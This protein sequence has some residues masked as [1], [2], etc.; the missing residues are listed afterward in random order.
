MARY[1]DV[2]LD[3][4]YPNGTDGHLYEYELIYYPHNDDANGFKIPEPDTVLGQDVGDLGPDKERYRWFFLTKN[5]RA[6]DNFEPIIRYN[7]Q[8]GKSGA[9]FEDGLEEV[10]DVDGWLRGFAYSAVVGSSD[11]IASGFEHNGMYYA[12]PDGRVVSL[13]HDMDFSWNSGL[14]IFANPE[15][16]KLTQDGRRRRIYLGHLHDIISTTFN[17]NYMTMWSIHL[18]SLDPA[19]YWSSTRSYINSRANNVLSQIN[20][21]ISPVGFII[22]TAS[23]LIVNGSAA[24]I[25]GEGWVN[26]RNIRLRGSS[27]PLIVN[28][29]DS[30]SWELTVPAPPGQSTLI[31]EALDFSGTVIGS[32]SIVVN[33]TTPIEPASAANLALT[34]LMYHPADPTSAELA[35]GFANE[36]AFEY[37]EVMNIGS[38]P[39]ELSG[40]S[41]ASGL[42]YSFAQ[43][44]LAPG[45]RAVVA[46]NHEAFLA[47]HPGAA[48]ALVDGAYRM[49]EGNKLDNGGEELVLLAA[50]GDL[51]RR[52][53]Y[54]DSFPWPASPDGQGPSLILI[55][56]ETNPDHTDPFN[57][58]PSAAIGGAAGASDATA[59]TGDPDADPDGNGLGAF[60]EYALG[61]SVSPAST[62][63]DAAAGTA[64][65]TFNQNL[66]ADDLIYELESSTDLINWTQSP[67]GRLLSLDNR[68]GT[69]TETWETPLPV[70]TEQRWFLRLKVS[71]RGF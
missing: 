67:S 27:E 37:F 63:F 31:L 57:W 13:P 9:A 47:R 70:G 51:I 7:Q 28:W 17:Q 60:H 56:P 69:I 41:F 53:T 38:A 44:T 8:F 42:T 54:R 43:R 50:D 32:Q 10:I 49:G 25:S 11:N 24:T 71:R 19:G 55:A 22:S 36:S 65:F 48:A 58:R 30:N 23:P 52:F 59:F 35:A 45:E 46:R 18:N 1:N 3:S 64:T 61:T 26:V 40:A 66:A 14:S 34:E 68:D 12:Q 4:Q 5:N 2:F 39:V 16:S 29:T 15:C 21:S 20:N 62:A 6:A 33:N